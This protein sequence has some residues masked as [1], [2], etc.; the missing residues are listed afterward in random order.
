VGSEFSKGESMTR[1]ASRSSRTLG[2]ALGEHELLGPPVVWCEAD[3]R[4]GLSRQ[5]G[6]R[7]R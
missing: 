6:R 5:A 1:V 7:R 2:S 3:C 4:P